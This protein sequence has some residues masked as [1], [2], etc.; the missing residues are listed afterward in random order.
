ME[1]RIESFLN[2]SSSYLKYVEDLQFEAPFLR[3]LRARCPN[4]NVPQSDDEVEI[5]DV[6]DT[7]NYETGH[8]TPNDDSDGIEDSEVAEIS[9]GDSKIDHNADGD[10]ADDQNHEATLNDNEMDIETAEIVY[11]METNSYQAAPSQ[12]VDDVLLEALQSFQIT[13]YKTEAEANHDA[14][15]EALRPFQI[16][17]Y[18]TEA[19]ASHD[20][21]LEV[22][23]SFQMTDYDTDNKAGHEVKNDVVNKT[24]DDSNELSYQ[25]SE[26]A[27]DSATGIDLA[28]PRRS[29]HDEFLEALESQLI[30]L[31]AISQTRAL[32]ILGLSGH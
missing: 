12:S 2:R 24:T 29:L 25:G 10:L 14:L 4:E 9:R 26:I 7:T 27:S 15:L 5:N 23:Q 32:R 17:D 8:E 18:K 6:S 3:Q 16:T 19:E 22:L 30:P 28:T 21:F 20:A 1:L 11:D 13:N 31:S